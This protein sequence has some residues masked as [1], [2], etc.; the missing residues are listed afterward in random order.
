[1]NLRSIADNAGVDARAAKRVL[2][3]LVDCGA[4]EHDGDTWLAAS[5]HH[6]RDVRTAYGEK[7]A[8][9]AGIDLDAEVR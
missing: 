6:D 7:Q 9:A 1:M 2:D 8:K 4:I 3:L 5:M